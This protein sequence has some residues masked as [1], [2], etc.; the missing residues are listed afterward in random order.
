MAVVVVLVVVV[1]VEVGSRGELDR[2]A[3]RCGEFRE[4]IARSVATDEPQGK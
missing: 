1:R 4:K 3:A 2:N